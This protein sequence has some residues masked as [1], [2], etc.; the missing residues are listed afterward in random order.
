[1][2]NHILVNPH[3]NSYYQ[4]SNTEHLLC[5]YWHTLRVN[6]TRD[7]EFEHLNLESLTNWGC[8]WSHRFLYKI[9]FVVSH[10]FNTRYFEPSIKV[11]KRQPGHIIW[12]SGEH[13]VL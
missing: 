6:Y 11:L 2:S 7:F 8:E 1:M 10:L 13:A 5:L 3:L 12:V 9:A 4:A